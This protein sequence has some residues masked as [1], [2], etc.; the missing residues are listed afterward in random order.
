MNIITFFNQTIDYIETTLE[1]KID[2]K[3]IVHYQVILSYVSR[4]YSI[5]TDILK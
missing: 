1:D 5:L 2:E 4:N 3:K